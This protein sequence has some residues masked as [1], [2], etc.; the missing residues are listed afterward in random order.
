MPNTGF[1]S[2]VTVTAT[3]IHDSEPGYDYTYVEWNGD[4]VWNLLSQ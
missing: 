2:T 1:S 4:G 3:L